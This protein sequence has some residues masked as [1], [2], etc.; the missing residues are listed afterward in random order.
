MGIAR[1]DLRAVVFGPA[2]FGGLGLTH[3]AAL[4]GNT[5]LQYLLVNLRC[6]DATGRLVQ[7]I[8]E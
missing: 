5:R 4:Q 8:L 1:S 3:L 7:I 2:Q 6:G